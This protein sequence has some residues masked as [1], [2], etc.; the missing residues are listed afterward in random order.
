[1]SWCPLCETEYSNRPTCPICGS[2]LADRLRP[3]HWALQLIGMFVAAVMLNFLGIVGLLVCGMVLNALT[4]DQLVGTI[5]MCVLTVAAFTVLAFGIG[6]L[7]RWVIT[8]LW[9]AAG[10]LIGGAAVYKLLAYPGWTGWSL[11]DALVLLVVIPATGAIATICGARYRQGRTSLLLV[12]VLLTAIGAVVLY[13]WLVVFTP[14]G[15]D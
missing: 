1:M 2:T 7:A 13:C 8:P 3:G 15:A 9:T 5:G 14:V 10:W 4:A 12:P 11:P 6:S